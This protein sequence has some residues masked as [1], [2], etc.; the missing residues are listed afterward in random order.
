[1]RWEY[2]LQVL[3]M[4]VATVSRPTSMWMQQVSQSNRRQILRHVQLRA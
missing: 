4:T 2:K 1:M 3:V